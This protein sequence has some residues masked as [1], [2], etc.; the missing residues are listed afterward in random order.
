MILCTSADVTNNSD[1]SDNSDKSNNIEMASYMTVSKARAAPSTSA[2]P[3]NRIKTIKVVT[4]TARTAPTTAA[5]PVNS[6][7]LL[8][9]DDREKLIAMYGRDV[10]AE[11]L[12]KLETQTVQQ[13]VQRVKEVAP[14]C[15]TSG[16]KKVDLI[17]ILLPTMIKKPAAEAIARN[18]KLTA[19]DLNSMT[20]KDLRQLLKEM[21][22]RGYSTLKKADLVAL[23]TTQLKKW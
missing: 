21:G 5:E 18:G 7:M 17:M 10:V 22:V 9:D 12:H 2:M 23:A 3:M 8:N 16:L 4:T 19:D 13:L 14:G 11:H 20:V 1:N 6:R 15:K